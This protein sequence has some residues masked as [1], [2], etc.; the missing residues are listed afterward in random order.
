[1]PKVFYKRLLTRCR[2]PNN[3][4]RNVILNQDT[5]VYQ[6]W[7]TEIHGKGRRKLG[8]SLRTAKLK[9]KVVCMKNSQTHPF[10]R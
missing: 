1:M 3:S 5:N 4:G 6:K 7:N 9:E 10:L 8:K 2:Y